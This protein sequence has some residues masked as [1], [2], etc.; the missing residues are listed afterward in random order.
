[1]APKSVKSS[2]SGRSRRFPHEEEEDSDWESIGEDGTEAW[3]YSSEWRAEMGD[4]MNET[5]SNKTTYREA[6]MTAVVSV[7]GSFESESGTTEQTEELP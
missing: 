5:L 4:I 2:K 6:A 3:E 1:L 7:D